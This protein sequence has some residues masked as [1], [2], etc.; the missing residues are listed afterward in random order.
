[1]SIVK[2]ER[3]EANLGCEFSGPQRN[4]D[5]ARNGERPG[6]TVQLQWFSQRSCDVQATVTHLEW[7][8]TTDRLGR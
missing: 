4:T 8:A 5:S 6:H 3:T 7:Q 1:M 2:C